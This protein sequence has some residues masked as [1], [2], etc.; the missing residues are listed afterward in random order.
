MATPYIG[1]I[2]LMSFGFAPKGWAL[3]NGQL[4]AISEYQ[5]LFSL[6]GTSFGGNG[7]TTFALPDLRGRTPIH[8]SANFVLGQ[9]GGEETHTL[10]T[11]EMAAHTHPVSASPNA[12]DQINPAGGYWADGGLP[13]YAASGTASLSAGAVGQT[14]GSEAHENRSPSLVVSFAI[15]LTGIFPTQN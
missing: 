4:M 1:E 9:A 7:T 6:L 2:R 12:A 3:C 8:M 5:A 13:A 11:G 15:A 14:G 10:T